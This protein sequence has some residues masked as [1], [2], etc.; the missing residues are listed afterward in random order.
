[1]RAAFARIISNVSS[2]CVRQHPFGILPFGGGTAC[3]RVFRNVIPKKS[4]PSFVY[5]FIFIVFV[6]AKLALLITKKP[7]KLGNYILLWS[8]FVNLF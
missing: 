5:L 7:S 1:M 6:V 2:G 4:K 3:T 8:L